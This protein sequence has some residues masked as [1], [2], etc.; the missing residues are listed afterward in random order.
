MHLFENEIQNIVLYVVI[1]VV[2]VVVLICIRNENEIYTCNAPFQKVL[3][4]W[5]SAMVHAQKFQSNNHHNRIIFQKCFSGS[6]LPE[7]SN[8]LP[9]LCNIKI[10]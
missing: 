7:C 5:K 10:F 1:V 3:N 4:A 6:R 2:V 8:R 9:I